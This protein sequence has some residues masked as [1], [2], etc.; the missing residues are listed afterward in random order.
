VSGKA[1][2]LGGLTLEAWSGRLGEAFKA[3][4]GDGTPVDFELVEATALMTRPP[5]T[6]A[7]SGFSLLFR[8]PAEPRFEQGIVSLENAEWGTVDLFVVPLRRDQ[9]GVFYEAIINRLA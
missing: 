1:L 8:G 3:E 7:G 4:H 9:G 2:D 6:G 5:D